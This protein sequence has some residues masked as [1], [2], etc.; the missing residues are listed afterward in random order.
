MNSF[1]AQTVYIDLIKDLKE[2][3]LHAKNVA[4]A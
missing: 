1:T 3:A 2:A 4:T